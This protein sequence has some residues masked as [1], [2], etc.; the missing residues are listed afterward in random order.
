MSRPTKTPAQRK[1]NDYSASVRARGESGHNLWFV[2]P[3]QAPLDP[4]RILCSDVEY[5]C[6]L[7]LEGEPDLVIIDYA[8]LRLAGDKPRSALRHFAVA[9]N[10]ERHR[11]DI[12]LDPD[13]EKAIS[14]NRRVVD[15]GMLDAAKTRTN[16]WRAIISAINR[17]RS[18]DLSPVIFRCRHLIEEQPR[19]TI[20]E[21]H[22][23]VDEHP[24]LVHG[25][26]GTMLRARELDCDV[27]NVFWGPG[28]RVWSRACG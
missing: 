10:L 19:I 1:R 14:P 23:L 27:T 5:E 3:P 4:P 26:I 20:A 18:H 11:L 24:A 28:T 8:P 9:T 22:E 2:S 16:S 7:Y 15:L 25:A 12:D 13:G 21:L 17:C 6:Y